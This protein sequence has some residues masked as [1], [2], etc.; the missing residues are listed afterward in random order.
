MDSE[1]K[2]LLRRTL[3]LSEENHQILLGMKGAARRAAVYGFIKLLLVI[4]PLAIGYVYLEP[5]FNGA[6][7]SLDSFRAVLSP[8]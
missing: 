6:R 1:D 7:E 8:R 2:A 3:K 4:I 5:Y